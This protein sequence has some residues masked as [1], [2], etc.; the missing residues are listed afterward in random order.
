MASARTIEAAGPGDADGVEQNELRKNAL[1]TDWDVGKEIQ[2]AEAL[3]AAGA[4]T[5]KTEVLETTDQGR[6]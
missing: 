4:K 1:S 6:R 5:I 3:V 2:K